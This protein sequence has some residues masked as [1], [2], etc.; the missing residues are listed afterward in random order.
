MTT[1][2]DAPRIILDEMG[3]AGPVWP[4][5]ALAEDPTMAADVMRALGERGRRRLRDFCSAP[6]AFPDDPLCGAKNHALF[7]LF[8]RKYSFAAAVKSFRF[9]GHVTELFPFPADGCDRAVID[10]RLTDTA[11]DILAGLLPGY[12]DGDDGR[13]PS[14]FPSLVGSVSRAASVSSEEDLTRIM[15]STVR[16]LTARP[17]AVRGEIRISAPAAAQNGGRAV[18]VAVSPGTLSC[19]VSLL[20]SALGALCSVRTTYVR[21]EFEGGTL[22][23]EI[24][25]RPKKAPRGFFATGD[26]LSLGG[27]L[28]GD[29]FDDLAAASAV[30]AGAD[31]MLSSFVGERRE[32]GFRITVFPSVSDAPEFKEDPEYYLLGGICAE[33]ARY[34]TK[35]K[36]EA[37]PEGERS[38]RGCRSRPLPRRKE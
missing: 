38:P 22:R 5:G 16:Q 9:P 4:A 3:N 35:K 32:T 15:A 19:I 13:G 26:V 25:A 24:L 10:G 28:S 33:L 18:S 6:P 11:R 31:M 30:A 14:P 29:S 37:A 27:A 36:A 23:I 20:S 2:K 12:A 8:S 34:F 1:E 21:A 17:G 7:R